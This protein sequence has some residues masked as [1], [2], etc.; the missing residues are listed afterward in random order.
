VFVSVKS[1]TAGAERFTFALTRFG[2]TTHGRRHAPRP[3]WSERRSASVM[4]A[5]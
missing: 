5:A 4:E 2:A 1:A 3:E